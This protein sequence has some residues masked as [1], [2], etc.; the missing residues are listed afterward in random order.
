MKTT[1]VSPSIVTKFQME[2]L[3]KST[4][5]IYAIFTQVEE[6]AKVN[7]ADENALLA[8]LFV[9]WLPENCQ[10][11][12]AHFLRLHTA[13]EP[14]L[15]QAE[16]DDAVL[17]KEREE[18]HRQA[19][20]ERKQAKYIYGKFIVMDWVHKVTGMPAVHPHAMN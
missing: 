19:V 12:E 11:F 16:P 3:H 1:S 4:E 2:W 7:N 18:A 20:E 6:L 8:S 5:R 14:T 17:Q 9:G 10:E 15:V 13:P